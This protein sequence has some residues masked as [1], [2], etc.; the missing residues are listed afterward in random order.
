M[1][2]G[3]QNKKDRRSNK[4]LI[5]LEQE[6]QITLKRDWGIQNR[7]YSISKGDDVEQKQ[8]SNLSWDED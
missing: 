1:K 3:I 7:K 6:R 5:S 4:E 8:E 2:W